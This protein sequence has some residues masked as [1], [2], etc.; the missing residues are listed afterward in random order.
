MSSGSSGSGGL[1]GKH[2]EVERASDRWPDGSGTGT[3]TGIAA[4]LGEWFRSGCLHH[5][6]DR[7]V[8]MPRRGV[9]APEL[10]FVL[11]FSSVNKT[12]RELNCRRAETQ[13][14]GNN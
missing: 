9:L 4:C 7:R 2:A 14:G 8:K 1:A 11:D 13:T 12:R 6:T 5:A 3:A 10:Q